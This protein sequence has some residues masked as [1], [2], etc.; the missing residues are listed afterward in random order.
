MFFIFE[1]I[2]QVS[3]LVFMFVDFA[4]PSGEKYLMLS[5]ESNGPFI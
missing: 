1:N 5:I 2:K 3:C 4:V